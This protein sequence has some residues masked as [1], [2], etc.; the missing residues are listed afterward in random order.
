MK[1]V[2]TERKDFNKYQLHIYP[3][4]SKKDLKI[5][6]EIFPEAEKL[7]KNFPFE[8]KQGQ[9]LT[10]NPEKIRG[11][12]IALVGAGKKED[13][14]SMRKLSKKCIE[15]SIRL[16]A[17]SLLVRFIKKRCPD[18]NAIINFVDYILL[19]SYK[20]N[21]YKSSDDKE[22]PLKK[23]GINYPSFKEL[24]SVIRDGII[25]NKIVSEIRNM[26]NETPSIVNPEYIAAY[27][28][29][30]AGKSKKFS[31]KIIEKHE[32]AK[33][34]LNG[35]INVGKSSPFSPAMIKL[36]YKPEK[37]LKTVSLVGK[38]ITFDSG[39][40]NIKTGNY[41]KTMKSD[42]SGAAAVLG[43]LKLASIM[44]LK[45]K[46][47]AYIPVS[48]NM[49]GKSSY[50]PDD[51]I[52]FKNGKSVEIAN[53]DAEG[54][55]ILADALI[56][57]SEEDSDAIVEFSTLTGS[58][59][60]ALGE[61]FSGLMCNNKKLTSQLIK[62]SEIS[63]ERLWEMPLF[64]DYKK[65]IKSKIADLKNADYGYAS[66]IKAA[67]FLN[68]FVEKKPFAHI[69]IAGSAFLSKENEYYRVSGATG[70]GVR[71]IYNFLKSFIKN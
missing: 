71:L 16:K 36:E 39:G 46:I 22:I 2:K 30:M 27:S 63:G 55:L 53:T 29:K 43:I 42:M 17:E 14:D 15:E 62:A 65:S 54:R 40:L 60:S 49:P 61:S 70:V 23:I 4:F 51:I 9:V 8:G 48:E 64:E 25:I 57:A 66:S 38:G 33:L 32:L 13:T 31:V 69:D 20:F 1:I 24:E 11:R 50:K 67:L 18:T 58:I 45:V 6:Y 52:V 26:I 41:M 28:K 21:K 35:L 5:V 7:K 59:V 47:S 34:R 12:Y 19:N 68:E 37:Y 10:F 44:K 56:L 3:I